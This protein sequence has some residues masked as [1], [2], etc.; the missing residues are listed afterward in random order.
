M[1]IASFITTKE[2]FRWFFIGAFV[3]NFVGQLIILIS[4]DFTRMISINKEGQE[5]LT[6]CKAENG[7]S[8]M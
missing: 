8:E 6:Y 3:F 4:F 1:Y 7:E 5:K 2:D